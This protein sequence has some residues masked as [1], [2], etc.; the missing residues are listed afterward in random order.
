MARTKGL[1]I[2]LTVKQFVETSWSVFDTNFPI[3]LSN[4]SDLLFRPQLKKMPFDLEREN[5]DTVFLFLWI[6]HDD[7]KRPIW[8]MMLNLVKVAT[9][10]YKNFQ[11]FTQPRLMLTLS[12]RSS[13]LLKIGQFIMYIL[14][15]LANAKILRWA[16]LFSLTFTCC[17]ISGVS[18][19][20]SAVVGPNGIVTVSVD[21]TVI[22][23]GCTLVNV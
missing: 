1:W 14:F 13:A 9:A 23:V 19:I 16:R 3:R 6:W 10:G 21:V 22:G 2:K 8:L 17:S 18:W 5:E 7:Q 20:T 4:Q 11:G 15:H 12:A